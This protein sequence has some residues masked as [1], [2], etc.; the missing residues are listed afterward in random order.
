VDEIDLLMNLIDI[1]SPTGDESV[2]VAYLRSSMESLGYAASIDKAGN[3]IGTIGKGP[4]HLILLGHID[5]VNG[6]IPARRDEEY[7]YGRGVVDAKGPLCAFVFAAIQT[8]ISPDWQ[9]SVIGAVGEEGD[10]RGAKYLRDTLRPHMCI[11]G[12]PSHWDRITLGY[13]GS[14]WAQY[15]VQRPQVH[16][17]AKEENACEAAVNFWKSLEAEIDIINT[18]RKKGFD[19]LTPRLYAMGSQTDGFLETASLTFNLRLPVGLSIP[20]VIK[21][22]QFLAVDAK[23]EIETGEPAYQADKNNP[24]VRAFLSAIRR[25]GGQPGF[26]LKMGTS[27]MNTVGPTWNCPIIAYGPGD[28]SLDHTPSERLPVNEYLKSIQILKDAIESV[29]H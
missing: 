9:I 10:S 4:K 23:L 19:Q 15:T 13:K 17:A 18:G 5:T 20:E 28:S 6:F 24:L 25:N 7:I 2:A 3:V 8:K 22:M 27:D 12:E 21:M 1:Y 26:V 16:S 29:I 11:I 14:I